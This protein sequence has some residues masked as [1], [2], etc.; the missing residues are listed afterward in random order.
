MTKKPAAKHAG[1]RPKASTEEK[2]HTVTFR[3]THEQG[4]KLDALGNGEWIRA[5]IDAAP[6]PRGTKPRT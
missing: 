4:L 6:W 3:R 5:Q 2:M 1:G